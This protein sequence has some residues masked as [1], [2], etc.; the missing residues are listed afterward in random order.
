MPASNPTGNQAAGY[1]PPKLVVLGT[2]AELTLAKAPGTSDAG[3]FSNVVS[4]RLLK[5]G[6]RAVDAPVVL[7]ALS[8]LPVV[9][10]R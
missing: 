6:L 8:E 5:Q 7:L 3:G 10:K 4:D 9:A 2:I 1:E